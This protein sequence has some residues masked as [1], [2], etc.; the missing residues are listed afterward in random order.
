[1]WRS[2]TRKPL[3]LERHMGG[4]SA[5][6]AGRVEAGSDHEVAGSVD[7]PLDPFWWQVQSLHFGLKTTIGSPAA[8]ADTLHK[9]ASV[10]SRA[11]SG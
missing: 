5:A 10:S 11:M 2:T 1:M 7:V 6:E 9:T 8:L 3:S 4:L